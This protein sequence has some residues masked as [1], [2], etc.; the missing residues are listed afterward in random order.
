MGTDTSSCP[1][2]LPAP[3]GQPG[4]TPQTPGSSPG[5]RRWVHC[6]HGH[7]HPLAPAD[8]AT[9]PA[10]PPGGYL[11]ALAVLALT[12][13]PPATLCPTCLASAN[14][15]TPDR[16]PVQRVAPDTPLPAA[17]RPPTTQNR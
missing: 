1:V 2:S 17:G 12:Q 6:P 16:P 13:S 8:T 14:G 10:P 11:L 5:Q 15:E 3:R 4:P 7:L 9:G